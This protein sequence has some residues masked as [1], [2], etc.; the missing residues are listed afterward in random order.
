MGFESLWVKIFSC[1]NNDSPNRSQIKTSTN[2][3][4]KLIHFF[5]PSCNCSRFIYARIF[6]EITRVVCSIGSRMIRNNFQNNDTDY[7]MYIPIR[8]CI[9]VYTAMKFRGQLSRLLWRDTLIA[10]I[11]TGNAS[12]RK[13]RYSSVDVILSG[14]IMPEYPSALVNLS[15]KKINLNI[16]DATLLKMYYN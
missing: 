7:Y 3:W 12:A 15:N 13:P 16:C 4:S 14:S 8:I 9:C 2:I 6:F 5:L 1:L 11:A 10:S